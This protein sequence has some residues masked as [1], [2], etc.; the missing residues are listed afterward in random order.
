MR[1]NGNCWVNVCADCPEVDPEQGW[2]CG[3]G[4]FPVD[5]DQP[6]L[7]CCY[8][9]TRPK[10]VCLCGSTRFGLSFDRE[11]LRETLAGNV[12]LTIGSHLTGDD[13]LFGRLAHD[14]RVKIKR[15]LDHLHF[16]KIRMA[17]EILVVC[18]GG[19]IGLST[20]DEILYAVALGKPVRFTDDVTA[21][22][23]WSEVGCEGL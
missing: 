22:A 14:T 17:D 12:V 9:P 18:P 15:E 7:V 8:L 16:A 2:C 21:T 1:V 6:P 3:A 10:I 13:Q 4:G 19:Y 5:P 20:C 23:F 11:S